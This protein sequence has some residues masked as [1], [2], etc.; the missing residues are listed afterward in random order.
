MSNFRKGRVTLSILKVKGRKHALGSLL[1]VTSNE[2][3]VPSAA[4]YEMLR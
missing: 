1:V 3:E 4:I 2:E